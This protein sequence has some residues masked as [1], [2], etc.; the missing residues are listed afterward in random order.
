MMSTSKTPEPW[1]R[2]TLTEV[3]AVQRSVLHALELAEEDVRR[4]CAGL[5]IE[6]INFHPHG[7]PSVAFHLRHIAGSIDRLLTYAECG[8]LTQQQLDALEAE[9]TPVTSVAVL[10][11]EIADVVRSASARIRCLSPN[12]FEQSRSVGRSKLPASMGGLLVHIADHTQRH[13]GQAVT[14]AKLIIARR[15]P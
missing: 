2:G 10:I 6:E 14:T 1:L 4:W 5:S 12:D 7:L 9:Q 15:K 11:G 3:P 8:D 13:V